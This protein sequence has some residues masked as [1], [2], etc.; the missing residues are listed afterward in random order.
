VTTQKTFE[1]EPLTS[2]S[3]FEG[4]TQSEDK[5]GVIQ[6]VKLLG[7]T[8]RNRR[9]FSE[10]GVQK[11]ADL[12]EGLPVYADHGDKPGANRSV[13]DRIGFVRNARFVSGDGLRGDVVYRQD[14]ETAKQMAWEAEHNAA[15]SGFS[16]DA[17]YFGRNRGDNY[18][19]EEIKAA[20][21]VDWVS[22]PATTRGFFEDEEPEMAL[23]N[24]TLAELRT[25]NPAL[26]EAYES[27]LRTKLA[28]ESKD[29][30]KRE[31][32]RKEFDALKTQLA[33]MKAKEEEREQAEKARA[34]MESLQKT[35]K[36]SGAELP[37][38]IV[39]HLATLEDEA[40][41]NWLEALQQCKFESADE[42]DETEDEKPAWQPRIRSTNSSKKT[43][44]P[45]DQF[46]NLLNLN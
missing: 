29:T 45:D 28:S 26:L 46:R 2:E 22:K 17:T 27:E 15:S 40:K 36:E 30:A 34:A 24:A 21:S 20:R 35:L 33:E 8:S 9:T 43:A 18:H 19:V 13:K 4:S 39:S 11:A 7:L 3:C 42:E 1:V 12:Y 6:N 16:H 37:E 44:V 10:T 14:N 41:D 25:A 32:E 5:P 38:L 31:A 23:E